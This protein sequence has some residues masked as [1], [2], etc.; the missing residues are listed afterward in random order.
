MN[1]STLGAAHLASALA[2]LGLGA[3]VL[4]E[5]KGTAPHRAIGTGYVAAMLLTNL[6]ALGI[7]RISGH[8]GPFH[9]MALVSL[10]A[11]A[12]GMGAVVRRRPGWLLRHYH[13][14][15]WSY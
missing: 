4:L 3:L 11:V 10:A 8:F 1:T 14:M 6:T 7:Y 9:A 12:W 15:A 2:A 13:S 5:G